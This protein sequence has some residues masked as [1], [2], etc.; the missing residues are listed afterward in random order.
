MKSKKVN[1][2]FSK[3]RAVDNNINSKSRKVDGLKGQSYTRIQISFQ[4]IEFQKELYTK[5]SARL[6]CIEKGN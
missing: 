2:R 6:S 5:I 1:T 3:S 4:P